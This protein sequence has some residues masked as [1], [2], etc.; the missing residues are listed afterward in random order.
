[1][2]NSGYVFYTSGAA[3]Q[4]DEPSW[5][6]HA[7]KLLTIKSLDSLEADQKASPLKRALNAFDVTMLGIGAIIG[8]GIFVL[9]G[10]K[11]KINK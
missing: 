6:Y 11:K 2:T 10:K 7:R 9:T 8:A 5:K 3:Q 4:P 1:M